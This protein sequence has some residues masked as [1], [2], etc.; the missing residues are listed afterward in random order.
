M[1]ERHP[2]VAPV[3]QWHDQRPVEGKEIG[4]VVGWFDEVG[5]DKALGKEI[6]HS[7]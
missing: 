3:V 6:D 2:Q 1:K 7:E 5:G 4:Q